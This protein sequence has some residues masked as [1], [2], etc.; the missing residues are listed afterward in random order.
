MKTK[1]LKSKSR[2][3]N[4]LIILL[5]LG[6]WMLPQTA[7][8]HCDS[9]D[10]PVIK[11]ALK[12]LENND[13]GLVMKW[14]DTKHEKEITDLFKKTMKYKSGDEEV[15]D[16]LEKHFLETLVRVH[17]EG[18][19]EPYTGL[20]PAGTTKQIIQLTDIALEE[21]DFEGFLLKFN[22]HL[23]KI[24]KEK[25]DKVAQL[26]KVKDQSAQKGREYVAA[27]VAYTHTIEKMHDILVHTGDAH[28]VH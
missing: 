8:A 17:R 23:E 5:A 4:V 16:L 20:K 15:Y 7:F 21:D 22:G 11:D 18:E 2:K 6:L 3:R 19:G 27:Y 12:A 14:I 10:G 26:K 25:Y 28:D 13:P 1:N 9:Y 24:L